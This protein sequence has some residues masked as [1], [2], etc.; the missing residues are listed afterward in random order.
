MAGRPNV[1][2]SLYSPR[3]PEK[4]RGDPNKIVCRS[5]WERV[6]CRYCDT[7]EN[8]VFWQSEEFFIPY[9]DKSSG[10]QRRYFP[11]FLIGVRTG[12][13][14]VQQI[15]IEVKPYAETIPPKLP[16]R[17][18]KKSQ[19]RILEETETYVKNMSKWE[20]AKEYCDR[21]GWQFK[22]ITE[23]ELF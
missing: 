10:K 9:F 6:F 13:G 23:K 14:K 7:S 3:H 1:Q 20:A 21:R 4:Y 12:D 16:K 15:L 17:M 8:I 2:Q 19:K 5:S 22:V 11:D 18:T